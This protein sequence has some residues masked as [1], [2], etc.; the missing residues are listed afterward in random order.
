M[1]RALDFTFPPTAAFQENDSFLEFT[2]FPQNLI[3]H[4]T[5]LITPFAIN[6]RGRGPAPHSSTSDALLCYLTFIHLDVEGPVLAKALGLGPAQFS[7]NI[8][9]M[10]PLLNSALKT[11]WPSMAPRPLD[12]N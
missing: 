2:G 5:D 10:R 12:D 6:A 11:K 7:G 4:W 9:R 1:P 3:R 8:D